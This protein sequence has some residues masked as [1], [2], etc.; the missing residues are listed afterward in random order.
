MQMYASENKGAILGNAWTSG[1]FLVATPGFGDNNCPTSAK[2]GTGPP[3]AARLMGANFNQ[4]ATITDR[5]ERFN[6]LCNYAPPPVPRQRRGDGGL[7]DVAGH[8]HDEDGLLCHRADVPIR[9]SHW[10]LPG[11]PKFQ[12]FI[13]TKDYRPK[14][15]MVGSSSRKIFMSDGARWV[16]TD[17][18]APDY[19]LG[20]DRSGTSPGGHY[21]PITDPERLHTAPSSAQPT[22]HHETHRLQPCVT[23]AASPAIP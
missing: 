15:N 12:G 16:S 9:L 6:Y 20:W 17:S 7:F 18:A 14:L 13:D 19:N 5:T 11:D 3:P 21:G 10:N 4:G 1:A 23:A 2:P 22:Q 8:G